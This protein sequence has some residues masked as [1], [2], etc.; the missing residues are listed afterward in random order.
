MA[1]SLVEAGESGPVGQEAIPLFRDII[2]Q[3]EQLIELINDLLDLEKLEAGQMQLLHTHISSDQLLDNAILKVQARFPG[4]NI[5]L[6]DEADCVEIEGD[7]ERIVQALTSLLC[8][9]AEANAP[10]SGIKIR[11]K[12]SEN[13]LCL[14]ILVKSSALSEEESKRLFD[15]FAT[16]KLARPGSQLSILALPLAR[17]I[18][19]A[20]GG[21][22]TVVPAGDSC[23]VFSIELPAVISQQ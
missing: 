23:N 16:E 1:A 5:D 8:Y 21:T 19:A 7:E 2:T 13:V 20:H 10:E 18:V 11:T 6:L 12:T 3:A 17:S 15:R 9:I 22:I 4:L 14:Q